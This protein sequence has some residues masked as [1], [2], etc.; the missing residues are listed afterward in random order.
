[1]K[2]QSLWNLNPGSSGKRNATERDSISRERN[3]FFLELGIDKNGCNKE[4]IGKN[5]CLVFL[6]V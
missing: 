5:K 2:K 6:Q 1:M 4:S 3:F